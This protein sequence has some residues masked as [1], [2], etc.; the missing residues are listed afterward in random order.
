MT[1][2]TPV[3]GETNQQG[4]IALYSGGTAEIYGAVYFTMLE[5]TRNS[6]D[7]HCSLYTIKTLVVLQ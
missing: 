4:P 2:I 7:V 5:D 6:A 1:K 3:A